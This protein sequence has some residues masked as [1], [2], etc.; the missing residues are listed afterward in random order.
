MH[1]AKHFVDWVDNDAQSLANKIERGYFRFVEE[2]PSDWNF[3]DELDVFTGFLNYLNYIWKFKFYFCGIIYDKYADKEY[4]IPAEDATLA[5][6]NLHLKSG[7]EYGNLPFYAILVRNIHTNSNKDWFLK[8]IIR[9][10]GITKEEIKLSLNEDRSP[11]PKDV[12][13]SVI[14]TDYVFSD[15]NIPHFYDRLSRLPDYVRNRIS[16]EENLEDI[17]LCSIFGRH[18][19]GLD[20]VYHYH[21]NNADKSNV[22]FFEPDYLLEKW[23]AKAPK[24]KSPDRLLNPNTNTFL[25]PICVDDELTPEASLVFERIQHVGSYAYLTGKTIYSLRYAYRNALLVRGLSGME[26]TWLTKASVEKSIS[27]GCM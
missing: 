5:A 16:S 25:Y 13:E 8:S 7:E 15:F 3:S 9:L 24:G 22:E 26:D 4:D 1:S 18:S 27:K 14:Q 17:V 12:I 19:K 10:K 20:K 21:T 11:G 2:E 23:H 6:F